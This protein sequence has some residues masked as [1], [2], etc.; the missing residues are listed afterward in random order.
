MYVVLPPQKQ[1][2]IFQI[3]HTLILRWVFGFL[4]SIQMFGLHSPISCLLFFF[5]FKK[6]REKKI[7]R[8]QNFYTPTLQSGFRFSLS[9]QMFCLHS[10]HMSRYWIFHFLFFPISIF[11]GVFILSL[12]NQVLGSHC[13]F[14][15]SHSP[16]RFKGNLTHNFKFFHLVFFLVN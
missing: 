15:Y 6:K 8:F 2:W 12:S 7:I 5:L 1:S 11:H 14:P 9:M 4:L 10:N 16:T 13:H 3:V